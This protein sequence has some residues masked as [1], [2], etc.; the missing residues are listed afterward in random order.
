MMFYFYIFSFTFFIFWITCLQN[1]TFR[2]DTESE[3]FFDDSVRITTVSYIL[4]REKYGDEEQEKGIKRLLAEGVYKAAYPLH[5]VSY[6]L[7]IN[8]YLN[9]IFVVMTISSLVIWI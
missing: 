8:K 4:E 6:T 5:D 2:F 1:L 3:N 7:D 9:N